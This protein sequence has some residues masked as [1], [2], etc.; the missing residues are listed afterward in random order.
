MAGNTVDNTVDSIMLRLD[1]IQMVEGAE[2]PRHRSMITDNVEDACRRLA[3]GDTIYMPVDG[4]SLVE[5]RR[6]MMVYMAATKE[7]ADD[8]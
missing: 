5:V 4:D 8:E 2:M 3:W 7:N 6:R 1:L